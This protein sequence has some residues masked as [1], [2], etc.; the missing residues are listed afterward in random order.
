MTL[1]GRGLIS[2]FFS[3]NRQRIYGTRVLDRYAMGMLVL[4][5]TF[6]SFFFLLKNIVSP[7]YSQIPY[8]RIHRFAKNLIVTPI[9][10]C[11]HSPSQT[12]A[13]QGKVW[14]MLSS[15]LSMKKGTLFLLVSAFIAENEY[16][17]WFSI[18]WF[19]DGFVDGFMEHSYNH[20]FSHHLKLR[21]CWQKCLLA[22][23]HTF[24]RCSTPLVIWS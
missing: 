6:F 24:D 15:Q 2:R 23:P 11:F 20:C 3:M 12:C 4:P 21:H 7:H 10:W 16:P 5:I 18:L 22:C 9:L 19:R 1:P 13:G 14:V 8:L 17:V